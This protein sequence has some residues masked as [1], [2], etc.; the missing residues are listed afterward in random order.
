MAVTETSK[1][2]DRQTSS[3]SSLCAWTTATG[4]LDWQSHSAGR[5]VAGP[6]GVGIR[7]AVRGQP[8][9]RQAAEVA[10]CRLGWKY[11][12]GLELDDPSFDFSVLSEFRDR[13]AEGIGQNACWR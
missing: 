3:K 4:S 1:I 6:A 9:R 7:A 2:Q 10:R 8:H 13:F 11:C 12:L 5:S